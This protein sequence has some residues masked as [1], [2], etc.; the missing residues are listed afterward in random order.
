MICSAIFVLCLGVCGGIVPAPDSYQLLAFGGMFYFGFYAS[1]YTGM[2]VADFTI[3][4]KTMYDVQNPKVRLAEAFDHMKD[5]PEVLQW[6]SDLIKWMW[7][8]EPEQ[9]KPTDGL[10]PLKTGEKVS[11]VSIK[12]IAGGIIEDSLPSERSFNGIHDR[13]KLRHTYDALARAEYISPAHGNQPPTVLDKEAMNELIKLA[14]E[15]AR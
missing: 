9:P 7:G 11:A 4:L 1:V 6:L 8:E 15:L 14:K 5:H 10:I 3:R 12:R 13:D 2:W